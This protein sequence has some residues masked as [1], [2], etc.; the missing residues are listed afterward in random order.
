MKQVQKRYIYSAI[1]SSLFFIVCYG[2]LSIN[3]IL[4]IILTIAF[5][6]GGIFLYKNKD[7]REYTPESVNYYYFQASRIANLANGIEDTK[8]RENVETITK[9]T[10]Q[11]LISLE[12]RPKKVEQVF[13]FFDYY[14][15]IT[16]KILYQY[17]NLVN[18]KERTS[19]EENFI[20]SL[21]KY[22]DEIIKGFDNQLK[23]MQEAR[24][25]DVAAEINMFEHTV[26]LKKTDIEVGD[27][28]GK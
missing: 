1:V 5:Y 14:M 9:F 13:D 4:S 24:M 7:I 3:V 26:G 27:S 23:N 22:F 20:S 19:K 10:D 21:P 11:I 8:I 12:Q 28:D 18:K 25:V 16:Y 15:D 6:V 17:K 2:L